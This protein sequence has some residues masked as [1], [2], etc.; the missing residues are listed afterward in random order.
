MTGMGAQLLAFARTMSRARAVLAGGAVLALLTAACR[1]PSLHRA[2][3]PRPGVLAPP[4][5]VAPPPAASASAT[6]VVVAAPPAAP[7]EVASSPAAASRC[8]PLPINR[9]G[10]RRVN[11]V[12]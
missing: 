5:V 7:P 12:R 4:P 8:D 11:D 6:G 3:S 9:Y 10:V 2:P 1:D